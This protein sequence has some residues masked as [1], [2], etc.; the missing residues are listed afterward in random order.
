MGDLR[1][2]GCLK[3]RVYGDGSNEMP[4]DS[5]KCRDFCDKDF[6]QLLCS[7]VNQ[8]E[9]S[10]VITNVSQPQNCPLENFV[11]CDMRNEKYVVSISVGKKNIYKNSDI[12]Y[13]T[14][15]KKQNNRH[16]SSLEFGKNHNITFLN[17]AKSK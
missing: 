12:I 7:I 16:I 4:Q 13:S 5:L 14:F 3:N 11:L 17:V 10:L 1:I 8:F 9:G 15:F 2:N 6:V